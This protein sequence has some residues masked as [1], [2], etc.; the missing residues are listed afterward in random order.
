MKKHRLLIIDWARKYGQVWSSPSHKEPAMDKVSSPSWAVKQLEA[1]VLSYLGKASRHPSAGPCRRP[2]TSL[3]TTKPVRPSMPSNPNWRSTISR[4]SPVWRKVWRKHSPFTGL[5]YSINSDGASK[6][7][8]SLSL[9]RPGS[10]SI[11]TRWT[12]GRPPTRNTAGSP[13]VFWTSNRD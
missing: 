10:V 9:S 5:V 6:P 1:N 4:P 12:T 3:P 11:R 2:T 7:P 8:T 13:Q